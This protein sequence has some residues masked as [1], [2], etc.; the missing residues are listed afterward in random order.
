MISPER[1]EPTTYCFVFLRW[2]FSLN[3]NQHDQQKPTA[4]AQTNPV[5]K[6]WAQTNVDK[7]WVVGLKNPGDGQTRLGATDGVC[8]AFIKD[9]CRMENDSQIVGRHLLSAGYTMVNFLELSYVLL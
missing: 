9:S 8:G 7:R 6:R 4:P 1:P 2:V 3:N 5:D